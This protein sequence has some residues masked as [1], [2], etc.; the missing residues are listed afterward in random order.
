MDTN[1]SPALDLKLVGGALCLDFT[2][3]VS[4]QDVAHGALR[5]DRLTGYPDL[6]N[7]WLGLS[8]GST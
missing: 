5:N 3:T 2:N 6:V 8:G 1:S 4:Q 7:G